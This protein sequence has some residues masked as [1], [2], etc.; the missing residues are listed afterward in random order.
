MVTTRARP[1]RSWPLS[2][3]TRSS[4]TGRPELLGPSINMLRLAVHPGRPPEDLLDDRGLQGASDNE[5]EVKE[6]RRRRSGPRPADRGCRVLSP[7]RSADQPSDPARRLARPAHTAWG[8]LPLHGDRRPRGSAGGV[9]GKPRDRDLPADKRAQRSAAW[10][11]QRK[12]ARIN[13]RA[14]TRATG[15]PMIPTVPER[16][17]AWSVFPR[18][19]SLLLWRAIVVRPDQPRVPPTIVRGLRARVIRPVGR[20]SC[21]YGREVHRL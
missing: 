17:R 15:L 8:G 11:A 20:E 3:R 18:P 6:P 4:G 9:G 14:P 12:G 7:G 16:D 13:D 2:Q 10:R 21:G 1:E 5:A 19:Q